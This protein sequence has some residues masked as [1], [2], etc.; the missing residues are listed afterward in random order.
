MGWEKYRITIIA[1]SV[2]VSRSTMIQRILTIYPTFENL[3]SSF[4]YQRIDSLGLA[5][6]L[7]THRYDASHK[8]NYIELHKLAPNG[9]MPG[10]SD[11]IILDLPGGIL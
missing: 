3:I 5:L 8:K 10:L 4:E 9:E 7:A 2:I 6:F 1:V 11:I